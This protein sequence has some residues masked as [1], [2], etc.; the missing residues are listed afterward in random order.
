LTWGRFHYHSAW[1]GEDKS[2]ATANGSLA[3][4]TRSVR[5]CGA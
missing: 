3:G 4:W 2:L 5:L 1:R